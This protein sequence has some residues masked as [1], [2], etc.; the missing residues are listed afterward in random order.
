MTT[1]TPSAKPAS[2]PARALN[3]V[4]GSAVFGRRVEVLAGALAGAVRRDARVLDVGCGDGSIAARLMELRPDLR[5]DGVDVMI[6]PQT[7]IRVTAF[8]GHTL[9]FGDG[10]YDVV[11][12]VDVL[13]HTPDPTH[14]LAEAARVAA[15]A[16][17]VKDHLVAGPLARPTLRLM[18]WVG[19][20]GHGV[21]LPYHYLDEAGWQ[22]AADV[23]GLTEVSRRGRLRL[24][25]K[26]LTWAF[27][28]QLHLLS[29]Y[30]P[31]G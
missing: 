2:G 20:R 15:R 11:T 1:A 23:A 13:H 19:N 8:D 28:R 17:V 5:I 10:A 9:P 18:D 3:A 4:H 21:V 30:E 12:L 29:V 26:P 25:P 16:V 24:Y 7:K 31:Q 22:H 14:S 27:D 6:R